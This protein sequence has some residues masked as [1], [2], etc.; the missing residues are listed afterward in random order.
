MAENSISIS[1]R[2]TIYMV[3]RE[4]DG[5]SSVLLLKNSVDKDKIA[6]AS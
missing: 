2:E 4:Q 3:F 5:R 6:K 1:S